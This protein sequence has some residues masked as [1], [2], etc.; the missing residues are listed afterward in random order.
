MKPDDFW[1]LCYSVFFYFLMSD[2]IVYQ[3]SAA[4][5]IP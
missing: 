1:P 5:V 2:A 3:N 4:T